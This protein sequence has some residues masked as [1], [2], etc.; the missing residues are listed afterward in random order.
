MLCCPCWP[1]LA[2]V[3]HVSAVEGIAFQVRRN[4]FRCLRVYDDF[5]IWLCIVKL[6]GIEQREAAEL[7]SSDVIQGGDC[8]FISVGCHCL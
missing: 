4:S 5:E 7:F 1:P 6:L 8:A 3:D 2:S